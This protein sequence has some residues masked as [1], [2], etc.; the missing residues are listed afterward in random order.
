MTNIWTLNA[1][2][3]LNH[4]RGAD[5]VMS[6]A[7]FGPGSGQIWLDNV[8]C[9]EDSTSF[10]ECDHAQWGVHDCSHSEDVSV[11]CLV[12][13]NEGGIEEYTVHIIYLLSKRRKVHIT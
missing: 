11:R 1:K 12:P 5:A 3:N 10:D 7:A 6:N 13:G 2:L 4:F 8:Q 9:E